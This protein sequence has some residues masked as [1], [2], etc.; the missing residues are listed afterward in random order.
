ML[1][2]VRTGFDLPGKQTVFATEEFLASKSSNYGWFVGNE[3]ALPFVVDT[4]LCFRR[5]VFTTETIHLRPQVTAQAEQKFLEEVIRLCE[6]GKD[7]SV[8]FIATPQANAVF[9]VV[10]SEIEYLEWGSYIVDLT[11]SE[12]VIFNTFD[13]KHKNVIRKAISSGVLVTTTQDS[14]LIYDSLKDTMSRQKLLFFPSEDYLN[15]L[16][17]NLKDNITFYVATHESQLQGTAVVV[18]NDL[19]AYYYYGGSVVKPMTGSLNLMQYEIMKDLKRKGIPLYDLMGARL[20][21]G[22]DSKIEGIQRFKK[23]FASGM[24]Q[25]YAF[26]RIIKPVKHRLFVA[27]VK[28]YFAAKGSRY[29]GDVIDQARQYQPNQE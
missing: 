5:M 19:G 17:R 8:D 16:H 10:P 1:E 6:K 12:D 9:A 25:G 13:G 24:R 3:F 14:R 29:S 20:I 28:G 7:I 11:K 23:R 26:R 21:T 2:I 4:K 18:H 15:R 27:A 22:D